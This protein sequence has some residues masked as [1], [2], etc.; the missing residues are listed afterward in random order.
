MAVQA[1]NLDL[2]FI[3]GLAGYLGVEEYWLGVDVVDVI[4][5]DIVYELEVQF[6]F[7]LF[8][9]LVSEELYC[10]VYCLCFFDK[11]IVVFVFEDVLVEVVQE[12]FKEVVQ[13]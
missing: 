10:K 4:S 9:Y 6:K 11:F 3:W 2:K 13:A 12:G 7:Y 1:I 8:Y 5:L